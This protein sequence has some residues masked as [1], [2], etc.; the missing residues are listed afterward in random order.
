M[1]AIQR[2]LRLLVSGVLALVLCLLASNQARADFYW[3]YYI[4]SDD[5]VNLIFDINGTQYNALSQLHTYVGWTYTMGSNQLFP[6]HSDSPW[7]NTWAH[8]ASSCFF[9]SR[10]HVRFNQGNDY[11]GQAWGTWTMAPAHYEVP[12]CGT[13]R[14]TDFNGPRDHVRNVFAGR[15]NPTGYIYKGNNGKA[16]QCDGSEI[17]GDGYYAW[18]DIY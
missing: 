9:C 2:L 8:R 12:A 10:N 14:A 15:G 1:R 3:G 17:A 18:I 7:E 16:R 11:G 5:P 13:H 6:D 4:S